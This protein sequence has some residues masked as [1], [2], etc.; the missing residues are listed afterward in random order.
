MKKILMYCFIILS[1]NSCKAQSIHIDLDTKDLIVFEF[2]SKVNLA[3]FYT[4]VYNEDGSFKEEIYASE[5]KEVY[6]KRKIVVITQEWRNYGYG[7]FEKSYIF[8]RNKDTMNLKCISGQETNFYYKDILFQKGNYEL[9]FARPK[10]TIKG[11]E[12][13]DD[14]ELNK[15]T[16]KNAYIREEDSTVIK[17][18][19]FKELDFYKISLKDKGIVWKKLT[20]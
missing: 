18:V 13:V 8:I 4:K 3:K 16:F 2:D 15:L 11:S 1:I 17:K 9:Q 20:E 19:P 7:Y 6:N 14:K 5:N 10:F 12:L